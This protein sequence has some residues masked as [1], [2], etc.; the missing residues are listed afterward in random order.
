MSLIVYPE[1]WP[2]EWNDKSCL[3]YFLGPVVV[4]S[5]SATPKFNGLKLPL[6]AQW[7]TDGRTFS[8]YSFP[9]ISTKK[10]SGHLLL[11]LG[12]SESD[13]AIILVKRQPSP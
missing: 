6:K 9:Y 8:S 7:D 3:S 13:I 10:E 11:D 2:S 1:P 5:D 4:T 12:N